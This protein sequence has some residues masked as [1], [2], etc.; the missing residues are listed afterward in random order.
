MIRVTARISLD[1]REIEERFLR[2]SGPGG[3]NVNKVETAVE[4]RFDVLNSPSLSDAVK[5]RLATLAGRR[6]TKEGVLVINAQ[7]HRTQDR[8]REDAL[9]RLLDLIREAATPPPP[10]RRPTKPTKGSQRRRMDSKTKRGAVKKL[11]G[12][13][14][15]D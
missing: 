15:E 4:L 9:E 14:V 11:R 12:P 2:A 1:P 13:S 8:N 6:M 3:Q 5:G 10:P 7:R